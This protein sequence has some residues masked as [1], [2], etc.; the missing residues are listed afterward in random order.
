MENKASIKSTNNLQQ[1]L[2]NIKSVK[3]LDRSN[4]GKNYTINGSVRGISVEQDN[5]QHQIFS[6]ILTEES[7]SRD[8]LRNDFL[9]FLR[10][11]PKNLWPNM[12][13]DVK[14]MTGLYVKSIDPS[15]E[16]TVIPSEAEYF[17]LTNSSTGTFN[18][19]LIHL[20]SE[21]SNFLRITPLIDYKAL[22]Y[23]KWEPGKIE[24]C[25]I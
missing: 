11:N 12:Y 25:K 21:L 14:N 10:A 2:E 8:V 17:A 4:R 9:N 1:A 15:P 20:A 22:D 7:L 13:V 18:Q 23:M 19:P 6:A 24:F 16:T 5:F 3:L